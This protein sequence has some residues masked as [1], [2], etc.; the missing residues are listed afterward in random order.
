MSNELYILLVTAASIGFLHTILGPD[1]YIPFIVMSKAGRWTKKK[2]I[3]VTVLSG[4]G[5]VMGSIV[6]GAIGIAAGIALSS[7]EAIESARGEIAAWL[8]MSFGFIYLVWGLKHAGKNKKHT[9]WHKHS[10]G[11]VHTHEHHHHQEHAHVHSEKESTNLTPWI[12][13]TIFVFG[14]CEAL[15]PILM[16]PAAEVSINGMMLVTAVFGITTIATMLSVVLISIYG[17]NF[18]KLNKFEKYSHALA[19][20]II[21]MSGIAVQFLNL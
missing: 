1:H 3:W 19:G 15:I 6:L 4:I 13:F 2:T 11:I 10:D 9:H 17:I 16:F 12:L 18:I 21:L 14:P 8:L 5:H 7:L 20:G